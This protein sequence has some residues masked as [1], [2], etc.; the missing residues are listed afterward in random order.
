[1]R[2]FTILAL[3][4]L[5][6]LLALSATASYDEYEMTEYDYEEEYSQDGTALALE[7]YTMYTVKSGDN[8]STIASRFGTTVQAIVSLN[9]LANANLIY[10]GQQLKIPSSSPAPTPTP[11]PSGGCKQYTLSSNGFATIRN[12]LFAGNLKQSQVNGIN[13]ILAASKTECITMVE[14]VAYLLATAYLETAQTMQPVREAFWLSEDWRRA[15]LRYYPYYGRGHVQLTW[16]GNY[17][18][19]GQKLGY[20]S[21]F[22]NSPDMVMNGAISAKILALGSKEGWFTSAKLS[23]YINSSRVDF[24]GARRIINGTD[25]ASTIAGYANTFLRALKQ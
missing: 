13:D 9:N 12:A 14:Q 16:Q 25:K 1:M 10:V 15:N 22:V 17:L 2:T 24:V 8:L 6:A 3:I 21:Q 7:S 11:T 20:G 23:D 18:K 5:I 19:A 4:A